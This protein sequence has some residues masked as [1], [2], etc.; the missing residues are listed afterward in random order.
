M[1]DNLE[2]RFERPNTPGLIGE[3]FIELWTAFACVSSCSDYVRLFLD[4]ERPEL[5]AGRRPTL[6]L[7]GNESSISGPRGTSTRL[8]DRPIYSPA[9]RPI[10]SLE[11]RPVYSAG[12]SLVFEFHSGHAQRNHTGFVGRYRFIDTGPTSFLACSC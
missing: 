4:L 11:D 1:K 5:S 3:L 9:D 6:E 8:E 10:H 12:R 7:C 2:S